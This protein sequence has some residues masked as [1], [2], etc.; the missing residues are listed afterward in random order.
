MGNR[1]GRERRSLDFDD[2]EMVKE[3]G[4]QHR[5]ERCMDWGMDRVM[6]SHVRR[7]VGGMFISC[8]FGKVI[9]RISA[10]R[11][12]PDILERGNLDSAMRDD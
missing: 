12:L 6:L 2:G 1:C 10:A 5:N 9:T 4:T 7:W 3:R 11:N 8:R